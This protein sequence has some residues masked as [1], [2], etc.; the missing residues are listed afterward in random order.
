MK[1]PLVSVVVPCYKHEKFLAR[2]LGSVAAQTYPHLEVIINDDC[3]PDGSVAEITRIIASPHWQNRFAKRT[4]FFCFEKNQGAYNSINYGVQQ[5][6]GQIV[7][8][9]N[10]DDVYHPE[11][12]ERM[13]QAMTRENS[14]F[15]FTGVRY[16]DAED[17]DVTKTN[18]RAK[19]Y[20][21]EQKNITRFPSVGFACLTFN[22][23]I[24]SGNFAF[25]KSL[26]E[27]VGAFKHYLHC[28]DWDFLLR[29]LIQTEPCFIPEALYDY[30]FHGTNSF[31]TLHQEGVDESAELLR[32]YFELVNAGWSLN[33]LAPSAL[34]W[35][36]FYHVFVHWYN[37]RPFQPQHHLIA[38]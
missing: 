11:R 13:V 33:S 1:T 14:E 8:I 32:N 27:R 23:G 2:S 29:C 20:C 16:I 36:S 26:Y 15:A 6:T 30:R 17:Q 5:A 31:E 38:A 25:T 35:P 7:T 18:P 24:S 3:S 21:Q 22:M 37:L 34:N 4:K 19:R 9:L 10:S 28:H 12:I